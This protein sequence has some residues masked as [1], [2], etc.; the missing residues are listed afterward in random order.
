MEYD[1]EIL[2]DLPRERVIELFDSEENVSKWQPELISMVHVSGA[3]GQEGGVT[4]LKYQMGKRVVEMTETITK[5]EFPDKFNAIYEAKGVLNCV[6]NTFIAV[7]PEQTKWHAHNKFQCS[8][9]LKL[10]TWLSPGMFK[11][12][13]M[14][15]LVNF[16]NFA[17][18]EKS[19]F[20]ET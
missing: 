18:N 1:C 4:A 7:S 17:E 16:K 8:G 9:F 13:T 10:M 15:Y 14:K 19:L 2:I 3:K 5:R 6:D 12:Q 11:K 20:P